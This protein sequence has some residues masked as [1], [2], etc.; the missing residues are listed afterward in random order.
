MKREGR[1]EDKKL[2]SLENDSIL[3]SFMYIVKYS[4]N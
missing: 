4:E 1:I 3:K 2:E